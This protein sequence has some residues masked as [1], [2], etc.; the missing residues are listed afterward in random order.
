[1]T[2][3]RGFKLIYK[4]HSFYVTLKY[5][6]LIIQFIVYLHDIV[7]FVYCVSFLFVLLF[8]LFAIKSSSKWLILSSWMLASVDFIWCRVFGKSFV[9]FWLSLWPSLPVFFAVEL[10]LCSIGDWVWTGELCMCYWL[11]VRVIAFVLFIVRGLFLTRL[12]MF[13]TRH[14]WTGELL[15]GGSSMWFFNVF[16]SH[17]DPYTMLGL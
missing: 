5:L 2:V 6:Y 12:T 13:Y 4:T 9:A 14:G 7:Y 8:A 11:C 15:Y 16:L 10:P 1:M 17:W 3:N